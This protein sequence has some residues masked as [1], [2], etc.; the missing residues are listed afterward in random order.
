MDIIT[1][2]VIK[3]IKE[4]VHAKMYLDQ[5]TCGDLV[6]TIRGYKL[7][8]EL[9]NMGGEVL[10]TGSHINNPYIRV[11][12]GEPVEHEIKLR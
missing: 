1:V 2:E 5:T 8:K 6:F 11:V 3:V 12:F 9:L 7:F 10:N 4:H